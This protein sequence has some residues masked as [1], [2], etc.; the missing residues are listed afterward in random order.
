[1]SIKPARL[2]SR[3]ITTPMMILQDVELVISILNRVMLYN[4]LQELKNS[5]YHSLDEYISQLD[6]GH[7]AK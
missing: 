4:Q 2:S 3:I 5:I 1:M 6:I 7:P